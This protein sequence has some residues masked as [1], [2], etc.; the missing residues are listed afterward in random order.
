MIQYNGT[1]KP[2]VMLGE[3]KELVD[4]SWRLQERGEK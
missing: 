3:N 4:R 2:E 1:S